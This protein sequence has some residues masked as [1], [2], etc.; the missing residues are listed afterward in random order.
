MG[1]NNTS[2]DPGIQTMR[3]FEYLAIYIL[4]GD[5]LMFI[6]LTTPYIYGH[7]PDISVGGICSHQ[8]TKNGTH[9]KRVTGI[10]RWHLINHKYLFRVFAFANFRMN[11][12]F[13]HGWTVL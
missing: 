10:N 11:S 12:R 2:K 8:D 4:S 7:Q 9:S 1:E 13:G 3:L 5:F 6:Q